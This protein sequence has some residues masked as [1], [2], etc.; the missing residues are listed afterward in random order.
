MI[1]KASPDSLFSKFL[2]QAFD[3]GLTPMAC[4][5]ISDGEGIT[6]QLEGIGIS[7][8]Y[9]GLIVSS[10]IKRDYQVLTF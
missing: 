4:K 5:A 7:V 10:F 8:V 1:S 3:I 2:R 6:T 9:V